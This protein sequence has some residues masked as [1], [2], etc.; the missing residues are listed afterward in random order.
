MNKFVGKI[1]KLT[2]DI[3]KFEIQ[4]QIF[5]CLSFLK[6]LPTLSGPLQSDA[7]QGVRW[8]QGGPPHGALHHRQEDRGLRL[9]VNSLVF[10]RHRVPIGF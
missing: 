7:A 1:P 8:L 3:C 6:P 5:S 2:Q 10:V 4:C 9:Y